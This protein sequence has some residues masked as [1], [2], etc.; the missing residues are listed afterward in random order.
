MSTLVSVIIPYYNIDDNLLRGCLESVVSQDVLVDEAEYLLIDDGSAKSPEAVLK[1]FPSAR[2]I[3][4]ENKGLG[5][6]RNTGIDV[7]RGE[8]IMFVDSDDTIADGAM[9]YIVEWCKSADSADI[10]TFGLRY[11]SAPSHHGSFKAGNRVVKSVEDYL[12]TTN[13]RASACLYVFRRSLLD[14]HSRWEKLRFKE[15]FLH[16]D[17]LFTPQ[18]VVRAK[19]ICISDSVVYFYYKRS[20]SITTKSDGEHLQRR[21]ENLKETIGLLYS[22]CNSQSEARL[23]E[24]KIRQLSFDWVAGMIFHG[25]DD[26]YLNN[27]LIWLK[28]KDLYPFN[29]KD[30]SASL[31]ILYFLTNRNWGIK[32]LHVFL[33]A[34]QRIKPV[35]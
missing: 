32:I 35:F 16:E 9:K 11:T 6:A 14:A 28:K 15:H 17:E 31:R 33:P 30:C 22:L 26:D 4:Q 3:R 12:E 24:R 25:V 21:M 19:T 5:G 27:A 13:L 18:L 8:Y 10:L 20:G 23:L 1:D 7:A 2:Y 29:Q 34:I